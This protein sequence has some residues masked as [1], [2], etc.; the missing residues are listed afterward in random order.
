VSGGGAYNVAVCGPADCT[1]EEADRARTVGALLAAGGAVVLC[2]GL[3]GVM[4]AAAEGA[5][6]A[7]GVAIGLLPGV[8][9]SGACAHLTAAVPTGLGEARNA[10]LVRAAD[11]VIAVGGSWGTLAELA[12][13]ARRSQTPVVS[14]GGWRV[15][16][17]RGDA[18]PGIR[19]V[20]TPEEAV[21]AALAG[22]P[23]D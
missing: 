14:L 1:P 18:V 9:R 15:V 10:V 7:G 21:D 12:L 13:A 17:Q 23:A 6:G 20:T 22:Q 3:G 8:D 16:D 11:A 19:H 4:A 5:S 2:G